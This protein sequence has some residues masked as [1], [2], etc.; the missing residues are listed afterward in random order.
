[1]SSINL[2]QRINSLCTSL[3]KSS[4]SELQQIAAGL[5]IN[6]QT[7]RNMSK[8]EL[9]LFLSQRLNTGLNPARIAARPTAQPRVQFA[10]SRVVPFL[11]EEAPL[12]V[13]QIPVSME[14]IVTVPG[15]LKR[16]PK[17]PKQVPS[18]STAT[19]TPAAVSMTPINV[20]S[21]PIV[22]S[23]LPLSRTPSVLP[24]TTPTV[25]PLPT[26]PSVTQRIRTR[27]NMPITPL[28][29]Q[30]PTTSSLAQQ[31]L[32]QQPLV[33]QPSAQQPLTLPTITSTPPSL[34]TGPISSQ[35]PLS[36][37]IP[38]T[39]PRVTP[40]TTA[41]TTL[42]I[43]TPI[44]PTI[45]STSAPSPNIA[46]SISQGH[47]IPTQEQ[48]IARQYIDA[49]LSAIS[50]GAYIPYIDQNLRQNTFDMN[51][52]L[53]ENRFPAQLLNTIPNVEIRNSLTSNNATLYN[54]LNYISRIPGS[55]EA[56]QRVQDA[57]REQVTQ[58][59]IKG[60][61]I[62][63]FDPLLANASRQE[64]NQILQAASE[65]FTRAISGPLLRNT[66]VNR[67]NQ[68][69]QQQLQQQG[70]LQSVA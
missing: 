3:L 55:A 35:I 21:T 4:L 34:L 44:T 25:T 36:S 41:P 39:L 46:S 38:T 54:I 18:V 48:T 11:E 6:P 68:V 33:Q 32:T 67:Y 43:T 59:Y 31:P 47:V 40:I 19:T 17:P 61:N 29:I 10:P 1:M 30:Q 16:R 9:C 66:L 15:T 50:S 42:P 52:L 37:R 14:P 20:P 70:R 2:P 24:T 57:L 49:I 51:R 26:R 13:S 28:L 65:L 45:S 58:E 64:F 7:I 69:Q 23:T 60:I 12:S 56:I 53:R 5:R 27:R 63:I 8:R 22:P 62:G